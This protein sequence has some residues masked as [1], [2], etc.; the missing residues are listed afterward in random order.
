MKLESVLFGGALRFLLNEK[1]SNPDPVAMGPGTVWMNT[2]LNLPTG[3]HFIRCD[4]CKRGNEAERF[5]C[6]GCGAPLK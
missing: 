5:Q 3:S 1:Q 6:E 4:Y 2:E